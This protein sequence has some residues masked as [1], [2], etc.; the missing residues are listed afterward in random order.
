MLS[1]RTKISMFTCIS[2]RA[3][4]N[5]VALRVLRL[6]IPITLL[7]TR[8]LHPL[9]ICFLNNMNKSP[10]HYD[11]TWQRQEQA[12]QVAGMRCEAFRRCRKPRLPS[13]G[14]VGT[15]VHLLETVHAWLTAWHGSGGSLFPPMGEPFSGRIQAFGQRV[16]RPSQGYSAYW[17]YGSARPGC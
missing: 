14:I 10:G 1:C 2:I 9:D 8:S 3:M 16:R 17:K 7:T 5:P 12:D 6:K 4:L 13:C 11:A 15:H